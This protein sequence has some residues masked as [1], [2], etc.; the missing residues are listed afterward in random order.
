M[1]EKKLT[2]EE[3]DKAGLAGIEMDWDNKQ[4]LTALFHYFAQKKEP[5]PASGVNDEGDAVPN[6]SL[7]SRLAKV[8]QGKQVFHRVFASEL[9]D[10][11]I[12]DCG[13][14]DLSNTNRINFMI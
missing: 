6:L 7:L 11:A 1:A 13:I 8:V 12:N 4:K 5:L 3:L 9:L 2:I 14:E 10:T